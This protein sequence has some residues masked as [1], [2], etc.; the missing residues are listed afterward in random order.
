[1]TLSIPRRV[2]ILSAVSLA[3]SSTALRANSASPA[4]ALDLVLEAA[5]S[6]GFSVTQASAPKAVE[7]PAAVPVA[8]SQQLTEDE[9]RIKDDANFE[10]ALLLTAL[11]PVDQAF[12]E[13]RIGA[14]TPANAAEH[15]AC[16][17][18]RNFL[19]YIREDPQGVKG[20]F[21]PSAE[22]RYCR[23]AAERKE[24]FARVRITEK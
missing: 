6:A 18:T 13:G 7:T 10:Q 12:C 23:N 24:L 19:W 17:V 22:L 3:L 16:K 21:P 2:A 8:P 15:R 1:M 4:P 11:E 5:Q 9:R 14:P 20:L